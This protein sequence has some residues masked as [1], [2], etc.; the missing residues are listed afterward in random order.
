MSGLRE[1]GPSAEV[2]LSEMRGMNAICRELVWSGF[3]VKR[4]GTVVSTLS[5]SAFAEK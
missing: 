4:C 1:L 5:P 2:V 3:T